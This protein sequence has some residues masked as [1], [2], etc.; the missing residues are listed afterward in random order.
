MRSFI[1]SILAVASL[2][3]LIVC[4]PVDAAESDGEVSFKRLIPE[5]S[6]GFFIDFSYSAGRPDRAYLVSLGERDL[7]RENLEELLKLFKEPAFTTM[8]TEYAWSNGNVEK[9]ILRY[10]P[11]ESEFPTLEHFR[12]DLENFPS[13]LDNQNLL[14]KSD[15]LNNDILVRAICNVSSQHGVYLERRFNFDELNRANLSM[16][17]GDFD[18][19]DKF[20]NS[21]LRGNCSNQD[22]QNFQWQPLVLLVKNL[23]AV[24]KY[25]KALELCD[26]ASKQI[27]ERTPG[28]ATETIQLAYSYSLVPGQLGREAFLKHLEIFPI[29]PTL[30]YGEMSN[31]SWLADKLEDYG[32]R[33]QALKVLQI[34]AERALKSLKDADGGFCALGPSLAVVYRKARLEYL[35]GNDE[36]AL[37]TLSNLENIEKEKFDVK[38]RELLNRMPGF[39]P[40]LHDV[41]LAKAA[42]QKKSIIAKAPLTPIYPD[43]EVNTRYDVAG[44]ELSVKLNFLQ[45][46]ECQSWLNLRNE[47]LATACANQMISAY[48]KAEPPILYAPVRQNLFNTILGLVRKFVDIGYVNAAK[49]LLDKLEEVANTKEQ[50]QISKLSIQCE[51]QYIYARYQPGNAS[52]DSNFRFTEKGPDLALSEKLRLLALAHYFADET[53]RAKF[54]IDAALARYALVA[55]PG[56]RP[57]IIKGSEQFALMLSAACIY[58]KAGDQSK[59]ISLFKQAIVLPYIVDKHTSPLIFEAASVF[60]KVEKAALSMELLEKAI[61]KCDERYSTFSGIKSEAVFARVLSDLRSKNGDAEKSLQALEVATLKGNRIQDIAL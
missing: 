43:F 35:L 16:S 38:Q 20:I 47:G 11:N 58:D 32:R 46:T 4:L 27:K 2:H 49:A 23:V 6:K 21:F 54:F 22:W 7:K 30:A 8:K 13:E 41:Q 60:G 28:H 34:P 15:A 14:R 44:H 10:K 5:S 55:I 12:Y 59:A 3:N 52:W 26:Y 36:N 33:D 57:S 42:V 50:S 51:R 29:K 53:A 61:A 31:E 56:E 48:E 40:S 17:V 25:S 1:A 19:A 45:A 24:G 37:S 39:F 18:S 9:R